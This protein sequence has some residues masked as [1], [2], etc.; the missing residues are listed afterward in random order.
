MNQTTLEAQGSR[1]VGSRHHHPSLTAP[2]PVA[3]L[4][5]RPLAA[6]KG[7]VS[8]RR[9]GWDGAHC[10][11]PSHPGA[12]PTKQTHKTSSTTSH[13]GALPTKQ[14]HKTSSTAFNLS[15]GH[16]G[17]TP[18]HDS[19]VLV[20]LTAIAPCLA[21]EGRFEDGGGG[22]IKSGS[23][24][25]SSGSTSTSPPLMALSA[26]PKS[27]RKPEPLGVSSELRAAGDISKGD[28]GTAAGGGA[29]WAARAW[30]S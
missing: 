11:K 21:D 18:A 23:S 4:R 15:V 27:T 25:T 13:P 20:R 8:G 17:P 24:V 29:I 19:S 14:T 5:H 16:S 7:R 12:L 2:P 1:K 22:G 26:A 3:Y 9:T 30:W 6:C 28:G 10:A